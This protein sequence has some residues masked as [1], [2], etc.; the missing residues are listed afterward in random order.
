MRAGHIPFVIGGALFDFRVNDPRLCRLGIM[1]EP[2][3]NNSLYVGKKNSSLK[4]ASSWFK[5]PLLNGSSLSISIFTQEVDHV[6]HNAFPQLHA[7]EDT[8]G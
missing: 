8:S 1:F 2:L 5:L 7:S 6:R 4:S 3:D